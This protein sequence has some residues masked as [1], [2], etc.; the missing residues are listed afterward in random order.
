MGREDM[1]R[2]TSQ[3]KKE[4]EA[5]LDRM[6]KGFAEM[7][8]LMTRDLWDVP[9]EHQAIKRHYRL[10]FRDSSTCTE[11]PCLICSSVYGTYRPTVVLPNGHIINN[12][13]PSGYIE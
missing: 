12:P 3:E 2:L 13:K 11:R 7:H 9:N 1:T 5:V 10:A 6:R 8:E 4:I